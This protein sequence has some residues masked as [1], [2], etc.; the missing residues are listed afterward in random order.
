[1]E[2]D[3]SIKLN[4][5]GVKNWEHDEVAQLLSDE[6]V[7]YVAQKHA[8]DAMHWMDKVDAEKAEGKPDVHI[9]GTQTI[10]EDHQQWAQVCLKAQWNFR[11]EKD[12]R[13]N[14]EVKKILNE[15]P[16][17]LHARFPNGETKQVLIDRKDVDMESA[18]RITTD[19]IRQMD[20]M[21][22]AITE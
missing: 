21:V 9:L 1:M 15:K 22:Y 5:P 16:C 12:N 14:E 8:E 17:R 18:I 7:R 13:L 19:T 3:L 11:T 6:Y 2:I 10:A 20:G 4:V